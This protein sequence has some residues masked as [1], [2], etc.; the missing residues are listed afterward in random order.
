MRILLI[1]LLIV[2]A[3]CSSSPSQ[4]G[5]KNASTFPYIYN[6]QLTQERPIKKIILA[7]QNFGRPPLSHLRSSDK[8]VKRYV[9]KYLE[10]HGYKILPNYH[11]ENAWK[12]A[13]RSY[14]KPYDPTTGRIDNLTWQ[15]V[16]LST[17]QTLKKQT[18]ADAIVFADLIEHNVQ[19]NIGL[20]HLARFNGV[21]RKPY[22]K[23][24]DKS[25][26]MGFDWNKQIKAASLLVNMYNIDLQRILTNYGGIATTQE[27]DTKKADP[28]WVRRRK[29][30]ASEDHIEEG[31][32][33]A[34]HPFITMENYPGE[35]QPYETLKPQAPTNTAG[36]AQ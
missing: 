10:Q 30:L 15:R 2:L 29:M 8:R 14:G 13:V 27:L 5:A 24:A 3:G 19:H 9:A 21:N 7:K 34:F 1:S 17:G 11:F 31:I 4:K 18:D 20:Q 36:Q 25:V 16:M 22:L 28:V 23:G 35:E 32:Q 6:Q 12:Q 26:P 33:I